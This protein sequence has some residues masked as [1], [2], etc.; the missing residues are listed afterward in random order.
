MVNIIA[1]FSSE[2]EPKRNQM[3]TEISGKLTFDAKSR[4]LMRILSEKSLQN[5]MRSYPDLKG[6]LDKLRKLRNKMAH[7]FPDTTDEYL[8]KKYT[9]R[10]RFL[11]YKNGRREFESG[12]LVLDMGAIVQK[13]RRFPPV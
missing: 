6:R 2:N 4:K 7:S 9:E 11:W 1:D 10:V 3:Y 8:A 5:T 12:K 13:I